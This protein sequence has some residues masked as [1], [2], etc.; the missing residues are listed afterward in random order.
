MTRA[1][2]DHLGLT[3]GSLRAGGATFYMTTGYDLG[4]LRFMGRWRSDHTM[5]A[6]IQEAVAARVWIRLDADT[7]QLIVATLRESESFMHRPP[8]VQWTSVF[9]RGRQWKAMTH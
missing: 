8:A 7:K 3:P 2:L 5:Q 1:G 6:Y 9:S 4:R